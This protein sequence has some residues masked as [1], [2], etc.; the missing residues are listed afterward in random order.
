MTG[1]KKMSSS[2]LMSRKVNRNANLW[3]ESHKAPTGGIWAFG[4][5]GRQDLL[6]TG[7]PED[8]MTASPPLSL[9]RQVGC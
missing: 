5:G 1:G 4:I 3:K 8:L 6:K 9:L 7:L 2:Y